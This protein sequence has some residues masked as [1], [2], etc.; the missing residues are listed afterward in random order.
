MKRIFGTLVLCV[1]ACALSGCMFTT[2]EDSLYRLPRLA[3]EYESLEAQI[4][5]LLALGAEY[6]APTS[7]SNLQSVQMVD[8]DGDGSEEAV[9]F[10]RV[11]E[12]EKP[13]KIYIF[14]ANEEESYEQYAVI[15]GTSAS[16]YSI[17][18]TDLDGD[19]VRELLVGY[20]S[21]SDVQGFA[22]YPLERGTPQALLVTGYSRYASVDM[23]GDGRQ[24]LCIV[25]SDEESAAR[26]DYYD[27]DG[28]QLRVQSSLRLSMAVAELSRLTTGTLSGGESA[29]FLTGVTGDG[30]C[31]TDVLALRDG[32]LQNAAL[33]PE[34]DRIPTASPFP[35]LYPRDVDGDGVTEVPESRALVQ[36]DREGEAL[37]CVLWRQYGADG[38]AR[39]VCAVFHNVSDGWELTLPE[40]WQLDGLAAVRGSMGGE[41]AVTFYRRD[42]D[43]A[44]TKLLAIYYITGE[45]REERARMGARFSL[46]RQVEAEYAAEL[47][48]PWDAALDEEGVRARFSLITAEW[49][50]SDN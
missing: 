24:E 50:M 34:G 21:S 36:L 13:M 29:V 49:T 48:E 2:S 44:Y 27:W 46:T 35:G 15:E 14:K 16:I 43:G 20:R 25:Y 4:E 12:D 32:K 47:F 22:V 41:S 30:M 19:G 40:D 28:A 45:R 9:A 39:D 26:V 31:F 37:S 42:E 18:Y 1:L 3:G 33:G 7:G 5:A 8:L 23:N 10:F 6:A 38:S 17:N 11:A